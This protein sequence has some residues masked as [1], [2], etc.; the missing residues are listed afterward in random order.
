[1]RLY[2]CKDGSFAGTQAEAKAK[3]KDFILAEVPTE[4]AGLIE[5]LNNLVGEANQL[6][7]DIAVEVG[8]APDHPLETPPLVVVGETYTEKGNRFEDEFAAMPIATQLHY[9][10]L[11]MENARAAL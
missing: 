5:Y 7:H 4:K 9:A 8:A 2:I 3:G 10:A 1:M 11:A 6:R